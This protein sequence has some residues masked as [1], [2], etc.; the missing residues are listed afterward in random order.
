MI[1]VCYYTSVDGWT[2]KTNFH[3]LVIKISDN[4]EIVFSNNYKIRYF[5]ESEINASNNELLNY[6]LERDDKLAQIYN[7]ATLIE[8]KIF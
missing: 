7:K 4:N 6:V 8:Y 3:H 5:I 1:T 2:R